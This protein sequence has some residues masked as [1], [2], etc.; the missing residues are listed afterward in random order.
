VKFIQITSSGHGLWALDSS[1][2]V[3]QWMGKGADDGWQR[4]HAA[5]IATS[6]EE[7]ARQIV[8]REL[9]IISCS[10]NAPAERLIR[11]LSRLL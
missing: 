6:A 5:Y 7:R 3:W 11:A 4:L 10:E 1:G 8:Y 2:N 9:G